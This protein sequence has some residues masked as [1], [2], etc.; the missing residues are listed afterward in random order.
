MVGY[1]LI[2]VLFNL[3]RALHSPVGWAVVKLLKRM[4]QANETARLIRKQLGG[5]DSF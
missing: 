5:V 4:Q 1:F 3:T 2:V